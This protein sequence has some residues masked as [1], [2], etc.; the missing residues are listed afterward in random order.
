ML[1]IVDT[2]L[3]LWDLTRFSLPWLAWDGMEL[4]RKSYLMSHYLET[5]AESNVARAVY[6][7][8]DV[9]PAQREAETALV[10]EMCQWDD[11]PMAGAVIGGSLGEVGF[12]AYVSQYRDND[13]IKGVRQVLHVPQVERGRCLG[14]DFVRDVQLLGEL[15]MSFDLCVRPSELGDAVDLVGQCPDTLF[16]VDHCGIANV[17]IV[18]GSAEH[19]PANAFSH[20]REQWQRDIAVLGQQEH[21][22]CKISGVVESAPEGWGAETL[23]PV[24]NHCLDSFGPDRV[25]F[26]GNWP[27]CTLGGASF[28]AWA[29]ALREIISGRPE[30]EQAQLLAGNAE[31]LYGL[32]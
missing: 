2:H 3:H 23:A 4:L 29:S 17:Q 21:V 12:R 27:V 9:D 5:T 11:N 32:V 7:E 18:N 10:I 15:G 31:R 26:A 28:G 22:V 25:V 14:A 19:D 8:V 30:E 16:I 1:P 20:T 13:Y 24:V 6:M